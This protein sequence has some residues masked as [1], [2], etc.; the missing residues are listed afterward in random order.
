MRAFIVT[1]QTKTNNTRTK[2]TPEKLSQLITLKIFNFLF[3]YAHSGQFL[4][5]QFKNAYYL[6]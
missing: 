5:K 3:Q 4:N 1:K 2:K 6:H